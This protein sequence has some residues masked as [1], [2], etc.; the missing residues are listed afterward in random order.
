VIRP[1]NVG[2]T[3]WGASGRDVGVTDNQ[4]LAYAIG[5]NVSDPNMN[6]FSGFVMMPFTASVSGSGK[7]ANSS[8]TRVPYVTGTFYRDYNYL[9]EPGIANF[10][11]SGFSIEAFTSTANFSN[12][13]TFQMSITPPISKTNLQRLTMTMRW[14]IAAL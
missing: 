6:A 13:E 2:R 14:S 5:S 9:F 7:V 11:I 12:F 8:T 3:E 10:P 4:S 1:V